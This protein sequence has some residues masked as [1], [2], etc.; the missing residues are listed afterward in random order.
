MDFI[1]DGKSLKKYIGTALEVTVPYGVTVIAESA[2]SESNVTKIILPSTIQRIDQYAFYGTKN[3]YSINLPNN[4]R[5]IGKG[6]FSRSGI[7]NI[8]LPPKIRTIAHELFA[9]SSLESITMHEGILSIGYA[10]FMDCQMLVE[11]T[12]PASVR[13]IDR[14]AFYYNR[15]LT[16]LIILNPDC[17]IGANAF[18]MCDQI[19]DDAG[20]IIINGV[21][22]ESPALYIDEELIIPESVTEI[23]RHALDCEGISKY[24]RDDG[25]DITNFSKKIIVPPS[26]R[27]SFALCNSQVEEIVYNCKISVRAMDFLGCINLR[28]IVLPKGCQVSSH[29]FGIWKE[30]AK[31]TKNLTIEYY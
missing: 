31:A 30:N 16:T 20:F 26:V 10:A 12:I 9:H 3:L 8:T 22:H 13:E 25:S 11:I 17:L 29:A 2:F 27:G 7:R 28:R 4:L 6:A 23:C 19:S 15:H 5:F 24:Y 18:G 21:L 1:I 14:Q